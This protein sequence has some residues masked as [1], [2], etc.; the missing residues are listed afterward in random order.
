MALAGAALLFFFRRRAGF[1]LSLTPPFVEADRDHYRPFE[2]ETVK[3]FKRAARREG[4]PLEWADSQGLHSI[5]G[6]ESAGWVG[7]PNFTFGE[8]RDHSSEWPPNVSSPEHKAIW[9]DIWRVLR[10]AARDDC[11][12]ADGGRNCCP[13]KSTATGLGQL[14]LDNVRL[15][16]RPDWI[17]D[18]TGEARMMLR[19]IRERYGTPEIAWRKYG[20]LFAGY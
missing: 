10:D 5:L 7:R 2:P 3:L 15:H 19:Y 12:P 18:A 4:L 1:N 6:R 20:T 8:T 17:G 11:C 16:G 13:A 14:T 9:P